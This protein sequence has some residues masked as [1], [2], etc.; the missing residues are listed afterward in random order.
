M[1]VLFFTHIPFVVNQ[2]INAT[3]PERLQ[4][5]CRSG[6][7]NVVPARNERTVKFFSPSPILACKSW[8]GS[9][10]V[11]QNF[12]KSP[13]RFSPDLPIQN[14]VFYF[15]SWGK[16]ASWGKIDTS[17]AISK[18][19]NKAVFILPS[20]AKALLELFAIRWTQ[21]VKLVKWQAWCTWA[22]A[23]WSLSHALKHWTWTQNLN[24]KAKPIT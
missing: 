20:E 17:F 3:P 24:R 7:T 19:F 4:Q 1:M 14:H 2:T 13:V 23:C 18:K 15:A 12:W 9:S 8:I 10:P 21:L 22:S 16:T 11:P 6:V 5:Y